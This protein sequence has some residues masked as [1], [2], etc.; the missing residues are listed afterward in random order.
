MLSLASVA[1]FLCNSMKNPFRNFMLAP[2]EKVKNDWKPVFLQET[3]LA[4]LWEL[5]AVVIAT[6]R[7]HIYSWRESILFIIYREN[8]SVNRKM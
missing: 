3:N 2:K 6:G 1:S 7:K 4:L 5:L 8:S